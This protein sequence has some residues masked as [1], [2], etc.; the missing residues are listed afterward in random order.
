MK[1][2]RIYYNN[3]QLWEEV[4]S[5]QT[6]EQ[7]RSDLNSGWWLLVNKKLISPRIITEIVEIDE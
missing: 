2:Y 5:A 6:L 3:G 1:K 4:E 7:L